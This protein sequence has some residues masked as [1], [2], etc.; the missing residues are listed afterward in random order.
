[1]QLGYKNVKSRGEQVAMKIG[2]L[3]SFWLNKDG[4]YLNVG[5]I[6]SSQVSLNK[7]SK[8]G[9]A[10]QVIANNSAVCSIM[11]VG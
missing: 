2:C 5:S 8:N 9:F 3:Q 11:S 7:T 4:S 6:I 1:M 10:I